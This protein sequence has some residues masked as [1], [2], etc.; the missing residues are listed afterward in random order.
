MKENVLA[1]IDEEISMG[2]E[3]LVE[4]REK[5]ENSYSVEDLS[6]LTAAESIVTA[7]EELRERMEDEL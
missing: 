3:F 7:F 5:F 6:A 1:I 4:L 2:G